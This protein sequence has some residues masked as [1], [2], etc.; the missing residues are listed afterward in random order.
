MIILEN[1]RKWRVRYIETHYLL[2]LWNNERWALVDTAITRIGLWWKRR[3]LTKELE[4][5]SS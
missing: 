2:Y 4:N 3:K 1:G 5:G